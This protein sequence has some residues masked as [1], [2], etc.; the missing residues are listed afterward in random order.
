MTTGTVE[1]EM[2]VDLDRVVE[3]AQLIPRQFIRTAQYRSEGISRLLG[4]EVILK[5]ETANPVGSVMGR[6]AE[7]WF[8]SHPAAHRVVCASADD[9]GMAMAH[10]GRSRG[11]EVELFGPT[12]ADRA[13]V[14]ALRHAGTTVRLDAD[15]PE[16]IR[17]EARRYGSMVDGML[18]LDG[19]HIELVEGAATMAAEIE[20][21]DEPPDA[22]FV[23]LGSGTLALG[24][25][26]WCHARMPRTRVVGVGA[27]G[28]PAMARSVR[29]HRV[30]TTPSVSTAASEL[31][32]R[33]PSEPI[34]VP[35]G[36]ALD[37]TAL[38]SDRHMEQAAAALASHEGIRVSLSGAAA[39]AAVAVAAPSLR[40]S[41]VVVAV[42]SRAIG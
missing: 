3:A 8:E 35:L 10:A 29:E 27:E 6:A 34:V 5:I 19:E 9:F 14:D 38:V 2:R 33:V 11:I 24:T 15:D 25:A 13:K 21:L 16:D 37:D 23:P 40:G 42:T 28:A 39:L 32:V 22:F 20:H 4:L 17:E 30:V 1:G 12:S 36:S 31:A 18:V 41:T 7:W 26:T